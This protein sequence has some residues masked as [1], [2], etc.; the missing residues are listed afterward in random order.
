[1][2]QILVIDS[3]NFLALRHIQDIL[4]FCLVYSVDKLMIIKYK[5]KKSSIKFK[6]IDFINWDYM[7]YHVIKLYNYA[8]LY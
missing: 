6:F 3:L 5:S 8:I 1:M 7:L 2:R 4:G